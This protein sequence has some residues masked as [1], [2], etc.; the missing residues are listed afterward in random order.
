MRILPVISL[1]IAALS[2][3]PAGA[4]WSIVAADSETQEIVVASATCVTGIDL[5]Q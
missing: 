1:L 4:T 3:V 5:K 2:P